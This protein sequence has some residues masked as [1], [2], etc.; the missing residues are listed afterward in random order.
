MAIDMDQFEVWCCE[1]KSQCKWQ[2][3]A[4]HQGLGWGTIPPVTDEWRKWHDR[5]CGGRLLQLVGKNPICI[6]GL[7]P[8]LDVAKA[9]SGL[10][11][12]SVPFNFSHLPGLDVEVWLRKHIDGV[13]V[14][15]FSREKLTGE[16]D[17]FL[18]A[19]AAG[20]RVEARYDPVTCHTVFQ[21][22]PCAIQKRDNK[23]VVV[24]G[25]RR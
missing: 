2:G 25:E 17:E 14:E 22:E 3:F 13:E 1:R 18:M 9:P 10:K 12:I 11:P 4:L 21:T 8:S 5:E 23:W 7:R 19:C 15:F 20:V 16:L 6:M 24:V